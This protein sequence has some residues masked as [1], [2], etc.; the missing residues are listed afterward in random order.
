M[1]AAVA[2]IEPRDEVWLAEAD[3]QRLAAASA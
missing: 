1:T 2:L 3:L